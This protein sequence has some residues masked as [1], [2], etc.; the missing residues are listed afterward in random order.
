MTSLLILALVVL[1]IQFVIF[2]VTRARKRRMAQPSEIEK[3][4]GIHT[5]ADAWRTLH[6]QDLSEAER[7]EIEDL[8]KKL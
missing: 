5:R 6:N 2:F 7:V 3:K 4:F 1:V 8:Y